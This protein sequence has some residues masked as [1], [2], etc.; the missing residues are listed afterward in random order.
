MINYNVFWKWRLKGAVGGDIDN[1]SNLGGEQDS[2]FSVSLFSL[3][4]H[5]PEKSPTF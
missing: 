2:A 1:I 4:P 3:S 5:V